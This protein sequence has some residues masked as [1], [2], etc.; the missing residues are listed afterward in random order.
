MK[1]DVRACGVRL[2]ACRVESRLDM[3]AVGMIADAARL[4]ARAT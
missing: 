4:E 3:S 1:N 2:Q